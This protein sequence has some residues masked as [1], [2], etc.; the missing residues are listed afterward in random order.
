MLLLQ[1]GAS[2]WGHGA[3]RF[4][5][6]CQCHSQT[7]ECSAVIALPRCLVLP[8]WREFEDILKITWR[9]V[10]QAHPN[11][12]AVVWNECISKAAEAAPCRC[13]TCVPFCDKMQR[14]KCQQVAGQ[15]KR[16]RTCLCNAWQVLPIHSHIL[17][18]FLFSCLPAGRNSCMELAWKT[19]PSSTAPRRI[20]GRAVMWPPRVYAAILT[21]KH[22]WPLNVQ[23]GTWTYQHSASSLIAWTGAYRIWP[24]WS[25]YGYLQVIWTWQCWEC[26]G[27]RC[28]LIV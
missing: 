28:T 18:A 2:L 13:S 17:P 25:C 23:M 14:G 22:D 8:P 11:Y 15:K 9:H 7:F 6:H 1:D 10:D 5:L 26:W 20:R 3:L 12:G 27:K 21:G 16:E 4:Y 24:F 19:G